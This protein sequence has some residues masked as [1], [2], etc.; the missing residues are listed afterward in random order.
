MYLIKNK[1]PYIGKIFLKFEKD[2]YYSGDTI[3]NSTIVNLGFTKLVSRMKPYNTPNSRGWVVDTDKI[4]LINLHTGLTVKDY[5]VDEREPREEFTIY[6]ACLTADGLFAGDIRFG[7][8]CYLNDVVSLPG[9]HPRVL[10]H[11]EEQGAIA[12]SHRDIQA[13]TIGDKL[14][15]INWIPN[16]EEMN[17]YQRYY[18][19]HLCEYERE[20]DEW[21]SSTSD[22]KLPPDLMT[23]NTWAV[24]YIPFFLR[25][26]ITIKTKEQAIEA[27]TNYL[28]YIG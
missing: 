24:Q 26:S 7:W 15:D 20:Y 16:D 6:N 28:K 25:G 17:L 22:K 5:W 13:F 14:F 10:W 3:L 1:T 4:A 19:K 8:E 2:P 27:A 21:E 18:V 9:V 11:E 12:W 23:M